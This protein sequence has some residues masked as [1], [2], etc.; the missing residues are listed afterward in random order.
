MNQ[1]IT[2]NNSKYPIEYYPAKV[3]H[4]D[5]YSER[6]IFVTNNYFAFTPK[7]DIAFKENQTGCEFFFTVEYSKIITYVGQEV[8]LITLDKKIIGYL[9]KAGNDYYYLTNNF[10]KILN[11]GINWKW[12]LLI[13]ILLGIALFFNN[14]YTQQGYLVC[15]LFA[16]PIIYWIGMRVYNVYLRKMIDNVIS[17]G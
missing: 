6:D 7:H 2:I 3:V 12:I 5:K 1:S 11:I 8:D 9:S 15:S 14:D 4:S 13:E 17:R 10:A 16:I